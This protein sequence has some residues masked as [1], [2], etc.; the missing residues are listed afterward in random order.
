MS[1][2]RKSSVTC[3]SA[4]V[5]LSVSYIC[6]LWLLSFNSVSSGHVLLFPSVVLSV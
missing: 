6:V 3:L 5:S 4:L 2:V 1:Q